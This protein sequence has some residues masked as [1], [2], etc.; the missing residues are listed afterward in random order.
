VVRACAGIDT[1][2][3][4]RA[5]RRTPEAIAIWDFIVDFSYVFHRCGIVGRRA[6]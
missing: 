2:L 5:A 4:A 1:A 6:L 3:L